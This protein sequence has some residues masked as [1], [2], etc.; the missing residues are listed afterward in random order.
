MFIKIYLNKKKKK[1]GEIINLSM[2]LSFYGVV[3]GDS[4]AVAAEPGVV[5]AVA[6]CC[7]AVRMEVASSGS[8]G[9]RSIIPLKIRH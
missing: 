1:F 2:L 9:T 7:N 4:G 6:A 8:P 3:G 5:V